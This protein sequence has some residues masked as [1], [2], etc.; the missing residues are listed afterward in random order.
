[1]ITV[2]KSDLP[3]DIVT[4]ISEKAQIEAITE[5]VK[6]YGAWVGI[7]HEIGVAVHDGLEAVTTETAKFADTVPGKVTIAVIVWK[8]IGRELLGI[9]LGVPMLIGITCVF[10]WSWRLLFRGKYTFCGY[11][12]KGKKKYEFIEPITKDW[13][14]SKEDPTSVCCFIVILVYAIGFIWI[15][16][17]VIL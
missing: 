11:D 9:I 2:R 17:G 12:E 14:R 13:S 6:R 8:V 7:G 5:K 1:L 15:T 16:A 10:M 4:K 3:P